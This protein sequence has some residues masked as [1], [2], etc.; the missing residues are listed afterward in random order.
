[1][2]WP[3]TETRVVTL[4]LALDDT[5]PENGCMRM[6]TFDALPGSRGRNLPVVTEGEDRHG[7][8]PWSTW[9]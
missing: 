7:N 4:W 1:M 2:Y 8:F 3:L 9:R 6:M 5:T